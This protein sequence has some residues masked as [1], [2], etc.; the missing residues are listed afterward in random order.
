MRITA[1]RV[2]TLGLLG[3]LSACKTK[4]T[5]RNVE[6]VPNGMASLSARQVIEAK[7][8]MEKV[9][10]R[11][12]GNELITSGK[13][14]FSDL[15]VSHVF[16]PVTG[17]VSR[18]DAEPGQ[19]VR[20]GE[21]LATI[22]SPDVGMAY[23]DLEKAQAEVLAAE[24]EFRRQK[25]LF[26]AHAGAQKDFEAAQSNFKKAQSEL[27]RSTQKAR[28]LRGVGAGGGAL[29]TYIL[30]APID[31][32]VI[33][34]NINPGF[35]I[36]GQYSGGT[37][38]ELFTIGNLDPVVVLADLYEMDLARVKTGARVDIQVTAYPNRHFEGK[39]IS[40]SDA[41]ALDPVSRSTKVRCLVPNPDRSLKPEMYATVSIFVNEQRA[42]A[43]SRGALLRLGDQ[44][45]VFVHVGKQKN[46]KE[47]FE[48]RPVAVEEDEGGLFLPVKQGLQRGE[49][50]VSAGAV[51]LT[52]MVQ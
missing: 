20:K 25:E 18:I 51:L 24:S 23:S 8:V 15:N 50:V 28:L 30:R 35:E 7:L 13:V 32:E 52:G 3:L 48:R 36:Q 9:D 26:E 5:S 44:T 22:E 12:V 39:V 31:G 2:V 38:V 34:R 41:L 4:H 27:Q 6:A 1:T 49:E 43:I 29:Q 17:R 33:S 10:F 21:A 47:L 37:P 45:V 19:K 42:L 16:S 14:T 40:V 11:N 46:G